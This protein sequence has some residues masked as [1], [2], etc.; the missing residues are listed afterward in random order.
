MI[1][2]NTPWDK[3]LGY[4]QSSLREKGTQTQMRPRRPAGLP[5]S[6]S[7]RLDQPLYSS[8]QQPACVSESP[9]KTKLDEFWKL[10]MS[11]LFAHLRKNSKTLRAQNARFLQPGLR[12][13]I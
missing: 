4:H 5:S 12:K 3:S 7:R 2:S 10:E 8:V 1:G 13:K 6:S 9:P 11:E